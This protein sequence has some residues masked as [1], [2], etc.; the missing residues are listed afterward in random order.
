MEFILL[1]ALGSSLGS[2]C[3]VCIYRLPRGLNIVS[4][5]SFCPDCR[6]RLR[7][8]ELVP[9]FSYIIAG[10]KCRHCGAGVSLQ[11]PL[12]E[13]LSAFVTLTAFREYGVSLAA[14]ASVLFLLAMLV[15]AFTDWQTLMIP[16]QVVLVALL[17]GIALGAAD[18]PGSGAV[19]GALARLPLCTVPGIVSCL[20]SFAVMCLLF[21]AGNLVYGK[22]VMGF[23]DVKLA[24]VI[25]LY[26]GWE[27][28]IAVLW[29][30]AVVGALYGLFM[31][32]V[33]K[34]PSDT[35]LPFG[36]FLAASAGLAL[37][38]HEHVQAALNIWLTW[39]R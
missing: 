33:M 32:Y 4:V 28:F 13:L 19:P 9:V 23:G 3:N 16:N 2:F 8:F 36:T 11:Y 20:I 15:V 27:M 10:G 14:A 18:N 24:G 35:K 7:W 39:L 1:F 38:F 26:V 29:V 31:I 6:A 17:A 5:R 37:F 25:G 12:V 22:Q 30:S 21:V 34:K